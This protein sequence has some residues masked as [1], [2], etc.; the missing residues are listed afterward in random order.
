MAF[1]RRG[2]GGYAIEM[3]VVT[4]TREAMLVL[5]LRRSRQKARVAAAA[6]VA[7]L[8][9][10]LGG[11]PA[12]GGPLSEVAGTAWVTFA[13]QAQAEAFGR[14]ARLG[15][16]ERVDV[17]TSAGD[18]SDE[19]VRWKRQDAALRCVYQ[20]D[21]NDLRSFA[22]DRRSFLLECGDGVVRRIQG[23]RG[24]RGVLEHRALPVVDARLLVNLCG[25][26]GEIGT[27]LDPF[28]GAGGIV[29]A[30]KAAGW[31]TLS[32]DSDPAL[33]FGLG[34]LADEHH[35]CDARE[36]PWA[37]ASVDAI[38]TEPPYSA[39]A[40]PA[41]EGSIAEIARVLR[42]GGRVALLVSRLQG[43]VLC[44]IASRSGLKQLLET[45]VNRKGTDVTVLVW[46]R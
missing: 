8:L 35:T 24:G 6:E 7:S 41:V 25:P 44:R 37:S 39:T 5:R 10:D 17:V 14:L 33:R 3:P 36:L 42:P 27:L 11:K 22:P 23:Y 30:A 18:S 19:I 32:S 21:A 45:P 43:D 1:E 16:S 46:Q 31:T 12:R 9:H 15:Y 4:E 40:L 2:S 26:V 38:A 34:E 29:I 28:A 20:E 13:A